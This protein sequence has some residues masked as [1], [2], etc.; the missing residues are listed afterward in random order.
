MPGSRVRRARRRRWRFGRLLASGRRQRQGTCHTCR[1]APGVVGAAGDAARPA[2][3]SYGPGERRVS[4]RCGTSGIH[5]RGRA[6]RL[7][8]SQRR[9]TRR[10]RGLLA[11]SAGPAAPRLV[12]AQCRPSIPRSDSY[13]SPAAERWLRRTSRFL[14]SMR[15][16]SSSAAGQSSSSGSRRTRASSFL[17]IRMVGTYSPR[18]SGATPGGAWAVRGSNPRPPGCKPGA[19]PAELTALPCHGSAMISGWR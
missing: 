18:H 4:A 15:W 17:S 2:A 7:H 9:Y 16:A 14:S 10:C 1:P 11:A 12:P 5:P 8:R 13:H 3:A 19:L 6:P